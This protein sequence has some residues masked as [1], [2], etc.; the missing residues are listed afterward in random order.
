MEWEREVV[1]VVGMTCGLFWRDGWS[2]VGVMMFKC[3]FRIATE[4]LLKY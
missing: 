4:A 3:S 1:V 2:R